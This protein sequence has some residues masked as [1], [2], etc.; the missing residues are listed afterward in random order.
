MTIVRIYDNW[1]VD[2]MVGQMVTTQVASLDEVRQ[3]LKGADVVSAVIDRYIAIKLSVDLGCVITRVPE[4]SR[5]AP[6]AASTNY[7]VRDA[8]ARGLRFYRLGFA[9]V[10]EV[11]RNFHACMNL[12]IPDKVKSA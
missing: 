12:T 8:G 11:S 9:T 5:Q 4:L 1:D 7:L 6:S 3:S 2:W 10:L